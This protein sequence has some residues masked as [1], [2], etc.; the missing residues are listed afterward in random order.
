MA[1]R[2]E[3]ERIADVLEDFDA[4]LE[5]LPRRFDRP[6][7]HRLR[8]STFSQLTWADEV[9]VTPMTIGNWERG[10]TTPALMSRFQLQHA[11]RALRELFVGEFSD[12][13][14]NPTLFDPVRT[15]AELRNSILRAALT[16]FDLDKT[17][18][19]IIPVPFSSDLDRSTIE[20]IEVDKKNLLDSLSQQAEALIEDLD[21]GTNIPTGKVNKYLAR[22]RDEAQQVSPN[23]RLLY[24]HGQTIS[25]ILS[26]D[27]ISNA[28]NE[29]D[30][31]ATQGFV[32][33]HIELM[34]LYFREALAKAQEIDSAD[35]AN[36]MAI[37][38]GSQFE[39]I[40]DLMD[41]AKTDTGIKLI[42]SSISTILRDIA[43]E[44]KEISDAMVFTIDERRKAVLAKRRSE[45]FK[46]GAV[47]VGRFVF[48]SAL[49]AAVMSPSTIGY[50]GSL[51]SIIGVIEV[52]KPGTVR[53]QY[54]R[55]RETFP[56]LPILPEVARDRARD[57]SKDD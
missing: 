3:I 37:D 14:T 25:R 36:E 49:I 6:L 38:D 46:T 45:A 12:L 47:Y 18:R 10:K 2:D 56:I 31:E 15:S 21:S 22:Y 5:L 41:Q 23:P 8:T 34:R 29:V 53:S 33:D 30:D 40:A 7:F 4:L 32:R 27:D 54:E 52:A 35:I 39:Q 42:N 26:S 1:S 19:Q 24:R 11:A 50:A 16:D 13:D 28:L 51:A 44:M 55:L 48:F 9:G 57:R 43:N 17:G 20:E